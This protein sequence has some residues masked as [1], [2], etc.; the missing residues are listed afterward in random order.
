MLWKDSV[1]EVHHFPDMSSVSGGFN[2][3]FPDLQTGCPSKLRRRGL[4]SPKLPNLPNAH[5]RKISCERPWLKVENRTWQLPVSSQHHS[6][7]RTV[8]NL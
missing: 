7:T 5:H 2:L 8:V 1:D 4:P 3:E 6:P